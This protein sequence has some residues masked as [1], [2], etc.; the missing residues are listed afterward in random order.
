MKDADCQAQVNCE[1]AA[2][3]S[4]ADRARLD[5][6]CA[7]PV[8]GFFGSAIFWLLA[9]SLLSLIA[10]IK[11]HYPSFLADASWLTYG[12]VN[13]AATS[14]HIYGW[15]SCAA[16][17][18]GIWILARLCKIEVQCPLP[19]L[20]ALKL[21]NLG[22]LAGII[23]L[24][25]GQSTGVQ[26]LEYPSYA[27]L[28]LFIGYGL[29]VLWGAVSC[30]RHKL[31]KL[32][33]S[34]CYVV[35]AF[36][37]FPW[38]FAVA[39]VML[40]FQPV[41]GAAHAVIQAWFA[42]N[43]VGLWLTPSALAACFYIIPKITG[44]PIYSRSLAL[45]GFWFLIL[46]S[47]WGGG[48]RL[49]GGPVPVWVQTV[50]IVSGFMLLM[51]VASVALN[52]HLTLTG[53]FSH[54]RVSPAL[55]FVVIGAIAYTLASL[56]GCLLSLRSVASYLQ[57]TYA[58]AAQWHLMVSVFV[59]LVFTGSIYYIA[60]RLARWEWPSAGL[61]RWHFWCTTLGVIGL[62]LSLLAG[63]I[64]QGISLASP[65]MAFMKVV[66]SISPYLEL[67][68]LSVIMLTVGNFAFAFSFFLLVVH[69][70]KRRTEP[71][72]LDDDMT[73]ESAGAETNHE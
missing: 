72:L 30:A 22:N 73:E 40:V 29:I 69:A 11:L 51:S 26:Y 49:V 48:Q 56:L 52:L 33:I 66:Q 59:G 17:G 62:V 24:L 1:C 68:S 3:T 13:A 54:L 45:L 65:D 41:Q 70:G 28:M 20:G 57:F 46:F 21:W 64:H 55:R 35:A 50:G 12:R 10:S 42:Q 16:I 47:C 8:L 38:L 67:A 5:A 36:F 19:L 6:A 34:A 15:A 43:L 23:G 60:P 37:A 4:A 31:C 53:S 44:R 9:A 7:V 14:A 61:V 18:I 25:A 27:A 71:T 39:Q 58:I 32:P 63:G 2:Q